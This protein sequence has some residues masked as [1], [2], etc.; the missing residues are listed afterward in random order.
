MKIIKINSTEKRMWCL[1]FGNKKKLHIPIFCI[2]V[3]GIWT[4]PNE[5][6]LPASGIL[7]T[8][9]GQIRIKLF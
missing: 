9:I 3:N 8:G 4:Q 5:F 1:G 6:M 2:K 7:E